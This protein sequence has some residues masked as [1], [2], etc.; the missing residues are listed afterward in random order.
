MI[1]AVIDNLEVKEVEVRDR[2]G[3]W[4]SM[5]IRPYKTTDNKIEGAVIVLI[6][7]KGR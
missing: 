3:Q 4:Y 1:I 7:I 2:A 5:R 6:D